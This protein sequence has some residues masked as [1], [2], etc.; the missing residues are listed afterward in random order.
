MIR[1]LLP[2]PLL[3][4]EE[5]SEGHVNFKHGGLKILLKLFH[6]QLLRHVKRKQM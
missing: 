3:T 5:G 1:W 6:E 4:P 2:N